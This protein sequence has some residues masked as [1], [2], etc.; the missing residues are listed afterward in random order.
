MEGKDDK[1]LGERDLICAVPVGRLGGGGAV[2]DRE[3]GRKVSLLLSEPPPLTSD[4]PADVNAAQIGLEFEINVS[5]GD[6]SKL[7]LWGPTRNRMAMSYNLKAVR[8]GDL[9]FT[10]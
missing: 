7:D 5:E 6:I 10:L 3:E 2:R 8:Q 9:V 4:L 1:G